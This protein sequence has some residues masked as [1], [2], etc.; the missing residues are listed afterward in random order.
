MTG[1]SFRLIIED[2]KEQVG[3]CIQGKEDWKEQMG[4]SSLVWSGSRREAEGLEEHAKAYR[5][6]EG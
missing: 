2:G 1:G 6:G 3:S 4:A 5:R